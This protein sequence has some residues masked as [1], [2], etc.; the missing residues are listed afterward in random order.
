MKMIAMS[1][2]TKTELLIVIWLFL[3]LRWNQSS[4]KQEIT[5]TCNRCCQFATMLTCT[6]MYSTEKGRILMDVK[7][8]NFVLFLTSILTAL[9]FKNST[10]KDMKLLFFLSAPHTNSSTRSILFPSRSSYRVEFVLHAS[11][12]PDRIAL[13][14]C[15]KFECL[16]LFK[17]RRT[18][19]NQYDR[20]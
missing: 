4:W 17:T 13:N 6:Q 7:L 2:R 18:K 1:T 19:C 11:V 16:V 5:I 12:F 9:L 20:S 14:I 10:G 3:L 8:R 15:R